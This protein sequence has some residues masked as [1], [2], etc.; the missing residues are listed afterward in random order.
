MQA[1][2]LCLLAACGEVKE[3]GSGAASDA[4]ADDGDQGG[5]DTPD[6]GRADAGGDVDAAGSGGGATGELT[7]VNE[8]SF[9]FY[10]LRVALPG[11]DDYGPNLA[12]ADGIPPYTTVSVQVE[13]GF[14]DASVVDHQGTGCFALEVELCDAEWRFTD[15]GGACPVPEQAP[16]QLRR[17][18]T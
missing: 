12:P 6:A 17:P 15:S 3:E 10:E 5:D 9:R 18:S 11:S 7:F 8:S 13:C 1:V 4:S 14:R 2:A 16:G